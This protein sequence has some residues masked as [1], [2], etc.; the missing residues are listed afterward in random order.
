MGWVQVNDPFLPLCAANNLIPP[1]LPGF[2]NFRVEMQRK[3]IPEYLILVGVLLYPFQNIS[4][5]VYGAPFDMTIFFLLLSAVLATA[6]GLM[7]SQRT[8]LFLVLFLTVQVIVFVTISP[9]PFYRLM[10]GLIWF[11]GL[12]LIFL[13]K[14]LFDYKL[15]TAVKLITTILLISAMYCFY[16]AGINGLSSRPSAWFSEPSFAGLSFY[17]ASA[18]FVGM[19]TLLKLSPRSALI[20]FSLA[21]IFFMAGFLTLSIHIVTFIAAI[22]IIATVRF[23]LKNL[24]ISLALIVLIFISINIIL[25][26]E[27]FTDRLFIVD[28][29]KN[30]ST[31]S[32]LAG[33]DQMSSALSSSPIF[34]M[35][36]GSTGYFPFQSKYAELML[37]SNVGVILNLTDAY[38]ALFR[39]VIE[40]GLPFLLLVIFFLVSI[41]FNFRKFIAISNKFPL[42]VVS[43]TV[44]LFIFSLTMTI[45]ILIKEP[46]YSRSFVYVGW[47]F[48]V[49]C[50]PKSVPKMQVT[51]NAN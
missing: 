25:Q 34:G 17:S 21:T 41:Y 2:A 38:S 3:R 1:T 13:S 8:F 48:L 45:G 15:S 33:F 27:H 19:L 28:G 46:T 9:A 24:P 31:L 23:T 12:V 50:L 30:L 22:F 51:N 32:W 40:L 7:I 39:I 35:G 42:D 10:S 37:Q 16:L 11:G 20:T 6:Q 14:H 5:V 18:G 44:F 43:P 4:L 36:L 47:L 29:V 49:T 26:I